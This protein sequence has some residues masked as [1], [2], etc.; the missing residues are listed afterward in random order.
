LIQHTVIEKVFAENL[1]PMAS[2]GFFTIWE[3]EGPD[4]WE[5]F[6]LAE[7]LRAAGP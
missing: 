4:P 2:S 1:G 7:D 5:L 6:N 3:G